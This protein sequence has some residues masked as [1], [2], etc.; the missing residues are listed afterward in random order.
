[1]GSGTITGIVNGLN[2]ASVGVTASAVKLDDGS[3]RLR[4]VSNTTGQ[5]SDFTLTQT[6]GTDL[7]GGASV[8]AGRDAEIT[9]G[10]DTVHSGSNTF[11]GLTQGL[12]VTL[13]ANTPP[14]TAVDIT[15]TRDAAG[16][17]ASLKDLVDTANDLLSQIDTLTAYDATNKTSGPLAGD[18]T[19][20]SLRDKV[21]DT[22]T[23]AAD[24]TTMAAVGVQTDRYGKITFDATVF[25]NA[26]KTDTAMV[27]NKLG[28]AATS[29]VPGFAARLEA[30]AKQASDSYNG[31][32]TTSIQTRQTSVKT[33]QDSIADWDVRLAAKQES[34]N[35]QFS[36]L[37]VALQ[38]LQSQGTWLSGQISSL[39]SSKSS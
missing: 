3:Y 19:V 12:D 29:A 2:S 30:M 22:V 8:V 36:A 37:E 11:T 18:A 14:G 21:L 32:L 24:G 28:G 26:Y 7:L 20:R 23:K 16:A 15:T 34:L 38:K 1:V 35:T 13:A 17:Q 25:A 39:S 9:V 4:V 31:T 33:L 27:A 5:D 10:P 6:D